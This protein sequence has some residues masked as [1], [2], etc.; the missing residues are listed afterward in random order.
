MAVA[1]LS[2]DGNGDGKGTEALRIVDVRTQA[3]RTLASVDLPLDA[4]G[5]VSSEIDEFVVEDWLPSGAGVVLRTFCC[6]SGAV[7]VAPADGSAP[8]EKWPAVRGYS[9]TFALGFDPSGQVLV[10]THGDMSTD[11]S[12]PIQ[13]VTLDPATG[14]VSPPVH[15]STTTAPEDENRPHFELVPGTLDGTPGSRSAQTAGPF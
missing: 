8:I 14:R 4:S 12:T 10:Q 3:T 1:I 15:R 13:V 5:A 9:A 11:G 7:L 2:P 6:D